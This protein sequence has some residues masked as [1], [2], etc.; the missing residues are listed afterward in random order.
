[1]TNLGAKLGDVFNI[2]RPGRKVIHPETKEI[3]G[4]VIKKI[5]QCKIV[6]NVE[7][8]SSI[9]IILTSSVALKKGDLA[10]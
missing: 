4:V 1:L 2:Y 7:T 3:I 6:D 10:E 5:G 9:A 8:E